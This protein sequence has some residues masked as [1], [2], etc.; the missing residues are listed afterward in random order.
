MRRLKVPLVVLVSTLAVLCAAHGVRGEGGDGKGVGRV[1][2]VVRV[3]AKPGVHVEVILERNEPMPTTQKP[4]RRPN[5]KTTDRNGRFVFENIEPGEWRVGLFKECR[6]RNSGGYSPTFTS[7]HAVR[8]GLDAGKTVRV[9]IGGTGRPV[10]GRLV[11]PKGE[12]VEVAYQGGSARR[13]WLKTPSPPCPKDLS[14]DQRRAWYE[15]WNRS[16]EGKALWRQRRTY[17]VDVAP[18]GTFRAEDIPPGDYA[19]HVEVARRGEQLGRASGHA[20]KSFTVPP[21]PSGR[22]DTP[23]D[24]GEVAA[25]FE[26]RLE[27]GRRAPDFEVQTVDGKPIKLADYKGKFVLLDFWAT[28][29][30]PCKAEMPNLKAVWDRFGKDPRFAMIGLSI[31]KTPAEPR[32][33][34]KENGLGWVQGFVK[35]GTGSKVAKDYCVRGVP[36]ILLIG[37][38]AKILA[39]GLRGK[40]IE[41]AVESALT[42]TSRPR[43]SREDKPSR[44]AD[45]P[46]F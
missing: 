36:S 28:W 2:G 1:E 38:D 20:S 30:G 43:Q 45:R 21:I 41:S 3:G 15:K 13:I 11:P 37:P 42:G 39:V 14:E 32:D 6:V 5:R 8:F 24:L 10:V 4:R 40:R 22:S 27:I 44:K 12:D 19:L 9:Q 35:G 18:D 16:D 25:V 33:Y 34:A 31:D 7:S 26:K 46:K 17:V 29:C 23:L